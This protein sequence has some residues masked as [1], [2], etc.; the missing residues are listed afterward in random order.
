MG[1]QGCL[2]PTHPPCYLPAL[3]DSASLDKRCALGKLSSSWAQAQPPCSWALSLRSWASLGCSKSLPLRKRTRALSVLESV[4][5]PPPLSGPRDELRALSRP[6]GCS[7]MTLQFQGS[8]CRV[9]A[10]LHH[11]SLNNSSHTQQSQKEQ[12][13]RALEVSDQAIERRCITV[14]LAD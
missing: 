5:S 1:N 14:S 11:W 4:C 2:R 13:F 3:I 7:E 6:D 12:G 9:E 10:N 8:G